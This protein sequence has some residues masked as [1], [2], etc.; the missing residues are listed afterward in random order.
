M[1]P[2]FAT[3]CFVMTEVVTTKRPRIESIDLLR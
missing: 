2:P 3:G 1:R